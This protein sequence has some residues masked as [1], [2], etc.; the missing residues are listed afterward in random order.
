MRAWM[1]ERLSDAK[2]VVKFLRQRKN[3]A[4]QDKI[5][6]AFMCQYIPGWNKVEPIYQIMKKDSRFEVY[7]LC[8]P[9][10]IKDGKLVDP[11]NMQNDTYDYYV[12][13]GY[14]AVN[15]LTGENEWLDISLMQL[16]YVFYLRPYNAYMPNAYVSSAVA[17]YAKI[18]VVMYGMTMTKEIMR[19]IIGR[20]FFRNVYIFF[21]DSP[22]AKKHFNRQFLFPNRLRLQRAEYYGMPV[23]TQILSQEGEQ[24]CE[25]A[26]S[27]NEFRV[28]WTPR[29]TTDLNL[30]G[31]NFFTYKDFIFEYAG[32]H[33]EI[34]FLLRPHPLMFEN[35]VRTGEMTAEEAEIYK[36][37]C[38]EMKNIALD[39][40]KDYIASMWNSSV[41]VTDISGVLAEYFVMNKPLIYCA[42]NMIL[43]PEEHTKKM[44]EGC[45]VAN[46]AEELQNYLEELQKGNDPLKEK[47]TQ[48]IEELFGETLYSS[49]EMIVN[50]LIKDSKKG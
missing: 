33:P 2:A 50:E 4:A 18:C 45:Y 6:V 49:A 40:S 19:E 28:M 5:R 1:N 17:N 43:H 32:K 30:G 3:H 16:D 11:R 48:I 36:N 14:E 9:S 29:W 34:S 24:G 22:S 13:H 31:T 38:K 12:E 7:L 39:E 47:R 41:L 26:F 10:G 23:I 15:T 27:E 21:A 35:F 46:N 37:T 20:E 42:S 8:I 25:W 44:L